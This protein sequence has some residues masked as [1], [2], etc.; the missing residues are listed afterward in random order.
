MEYRKLGGTDVNVSL[1]CLGTMTFGEQNTQEEG[2]AQMDYALE[3]GVNFFDTAEL[4][5]VPPRAETYGRTEEIIGEWFKVS[6]K[7]K[8][9]VLATKVAGPAPGMPWIRGGNAK[10]EKE[11]ILQAAENS[12]KR[13]QTDYIDLYQIH[14]PQRPVNSFGKLGYDQSAVS[15]MESDN[16]L[17]ILDALGELID[18]GKVRHAGLSNE[19]PWGVMN[20][21]NHHENNSLPRVVSIQ[22]AYSLLNR[23]FE[24][25][26]AEVALQENVGL[27]AY[28][29]LAA[30]TL[31]GK[32]LAGAVPKGSRWDIDTRTSRYKRPNLDDA[33]HA[34]LDVAQKHDLDPTQMAI[35]FVNS[36]P[37]V[38]STIIGAT[39]MEQLQ[40]NI[41]A[42]ELKL[43]PEVVTDINGVHALISN[44]C[45]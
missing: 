9:I 20:Y 26:L 7:R 30:G 41:A 37:F 14:W 10:L 23:S 18:A 27:L 17:E 24:V 16:I 44:P 12:L 42:A 36:R 19:T 4:Y 3:Q 8:D 25:G 40:S 22:N 45:P 33:V 43:A 32:Y 2:F 1:I 21:I 39:K 11:Q 34:Y 15:G 28:S 31:S 35:A 13:L 38:T 29:P 6:G 5:A